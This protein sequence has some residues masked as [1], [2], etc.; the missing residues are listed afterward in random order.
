MPVTRNEPPPQSPMPPHFPSREAA[1]GSSSVRQ[2]GEPTP[3][4]ILPRG[5]KGRHSLA[6]VFPGFRWVTLRSRRTPGMI[7]ASP[8]QMN[9]SWGQESG[10][11]YLPDQTN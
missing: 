4:T 3:P 6:E 11:I 9:G 10:R 5:P 7:G 1:K 8:A 2:G